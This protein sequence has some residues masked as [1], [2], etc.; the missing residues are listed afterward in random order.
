M[1]MDRETADRIIAEIRDCVT[2][3]I[4]EEYY[5]YEDVDDALYTEPGTWIDPDDLV[6]ICREI[7]GD[8]DPLDILDSAFIACTDTPVWADAMLDMIG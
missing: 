7:V 1:D 6:D 3:H 2:P 5:S 4:G 8:G